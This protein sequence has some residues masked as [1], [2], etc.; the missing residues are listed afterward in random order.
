MIKWG[1]AKRGLFED[2]FIYSSGLVF[3]LLWDFIVNLLRAA[4]VDLFTH[5]PE[6]HPLHYGKLQII[7]LVFCTLQ[8]TR[9]IADWRFYC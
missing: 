7:G 5:E 3:I 9:K 6:L 2:I 8:L 4:G 1:D